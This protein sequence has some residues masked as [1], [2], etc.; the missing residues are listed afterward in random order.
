MARGV[1]A[2]CLAC[3]F[4]V[5]GDPAVARASMARASAAA[6][7]ECQKQERQAGG[8]RVRGVVAPHGV[9]GRART[10]DRGRALRLS[11]ALEPRLP[12]PAAVARMNADLRRRLGVLFGAHAARHGGGSGSHAPEPGEIRVPL[13]VHIIKDGMLGLPDS[14]V[15]RQVQALNEAYGGKFGGVDTRVRFDLKGV[16]H[17][18]NHAWFRDPLG[19]EAALKDKLRVGGPE[20]LNLYMAQLGELVLGYSTY[21]YWYGDKPGLDGVVIDWRSVPG[22]PLR[23][24]NRGFTAVHEIGHWLGLLHTFENGCDAPGDSVD[25]TPPEAHATMGCPKRKDTCPAPG[26]DPVHNFMDYSHDR[27]M[28]EFTTGQAARIRKMW[29]AYR[30]PDRAR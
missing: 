17:T 30:D 21:P 15:D 13:W 12:G 25:D 26:D 11:H 10:R 4:V 24:F 22:G 16:T 7:S 3:L 6:P 23:N 1:I 19:N 5:G 20:T 29:A 2:V 9:R 27:C 28:R 18:E 8:G 14:A